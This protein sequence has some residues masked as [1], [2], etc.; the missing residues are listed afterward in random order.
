MQN[1]EKYDTE[2]VQL[3][4]LPSAGSAALMES[5]NR[6][7]AYAKAVDKRKVDVRQVVNALVLEIIPDSEALEKAQQHHKTVSNWS[8]S[9]VKLK[10][11]ERANRRMEKA[12]QRFDY[13]HLRDDLRKRI[14]PIVNKIVEMER[15]WEYNMFRSYQNAANSYEDN[16]T[17]AKPF[18][19]ND[20][21][22]GLRVWLRGHG[23]IVAPSYLPPAA[24]FPKTDW[25]EVKQ[26]DCGYD[27]IALAKAADLLMKKYK[28]L[29][30]PFSGTLYGSAEHDPNSKVGCVCVSWTTVDAKTVKGRFMVP[31]LGFSG[32]APTA[33]NNML[34][35]CLAACALPPFV[36]LD[37]EAFNS[38]IDPHK[39]ASTAKT[40]SG[41][42]NYY[43]E[44]IVR[45]NNLAV[46]YAIRKMLKMRLPSRQAML[47][48]AGLNFN[49]NVKLTDKTANGFSRLSAP[50]PTIARWHSLNCAEPAALAWI[51]CYFADG[52][53]VVL[54]CPYEGKDDPGPHGLKPKETCPW[55]ATVELAY[56]SL[57]RVTEKETWKNQYD[58][59][60]KKGEWGGE[61]TLSRDFENEKFDL[62]LRVNLPRN[63]AEM[64]PAY[65]EVVNDNVAILRELFKEL[66]LLTP[67]NIRVLKEP[68]WAPNFA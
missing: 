54:C 21:F 67:D 50:S 61:I 28:I 44:I 43:D 25:I 36:G 5:I 45:A 1:P 53:D 60:M 17:M 66:G 24:V 7:N 23:F 41:F 57:A 34:E 4:K 18:Y 48:Y 56:R 51:A 27:Y 65:P 14:E 20:Y 3:A 58:T 64:D 33:K 35:A 22:E 42:T 37:A 8:P 31:V 2:Q 63:K 30:T 15:R 68:L 16:I 62:R 29:G 32:K 12:R 19:K 26:K 46:N 38:E 47:S 52:Q 59:G 6:L 40:T 10:A 11:I 13:L 55:C 49:A 9:R 39:S